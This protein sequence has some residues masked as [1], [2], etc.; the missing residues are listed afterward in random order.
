MTRQ[1]LEQQVLEGNASGSGRSRTIAAA[2]AATMIGGA[3]LPAVTDTAPEVIA[4]ESSSTGNTIEYKF[5]DAIVELDR[6]GLVPK[7]VTIYVN[8]KPVTVTK[9]GQTKVE[10]AKHK[11]FLKDNGSY[12]DKIKTDSAFE[13]YRKNPTYDNG[14]NSEY[15]LAFEKF[16]DLM[17]SRMLTVDGKMTSR[18]ASGGTIWEY[19][20]A[21]TGNDPDINRQNES[22]TDLAKIQRTLPGYPESKIDGKA[23]ITTMNYLIR[24]YEINILNPLEAALYGAAMMKAVSEAYT[25]NAEAQQERNDLIAKYTTDL[26]AV[27]DELSNIKASQGELGKDK[28][29]IHTKVSEIETKVKSLYQIFMPPEGE[30][31]ENL[32]TTI[33]NMNNELI[34]IKNTLGE[35]SLLNSDT[36]IEKLDKLLAK[37]LV[38]KG[39]G[40]GSSA[41]G[42]YNVN[43]PVDFR[44]LMNGFEEQGMG[45]ST[46]HGKRTVTLST[47]HGPVKIVEDTE[48]YTIK[49]KIGPVIFDVYQKHTRE[50]QG[51][52][53]GNGVMKAET[54]ERGF[55]AGYGGAEEGGHGFNAGGGINRSVYKSKVKN[56]QG[57]TDNTQ[58][59][60]ELYKLH[61]FV[62][63]LYRA[64]ENVLST[65][66]VIVNGG[67]DYN[68]PGVPS[69][70][71][72]GD[73]QE[74]AVTA[75]VGA[76]LDFGKYL[77]IGANSNFEYS[78]DSHP[79]QDS[80]EEV[81]RITGDI[82]LDTGVGSEI[83]VNSIILRYTPGA[84]YSEHKFDHPDISDANVPLVESQDGTGKL[85]G[86]I[87][88]K[89]T[90]N[91]RIG[92]SGYWGKEKLVTPNGE[93]AS[94]FH[95]ERT[96]TDSGVFLEF[97]VDF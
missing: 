64:V 83:G 51:T 93:T 2:V 71:V 12:F 84:F 14:K 3:T 45:V 43:S 95:R 70:S 19:G 44:Y 68:G 94:P 21:N 8:G 27:M 40:G 20:A 18:S 52:G 82:Y 5:G 13:I 92:I 4:Q 38:C 17:Y 78:H 29:T 15:I 85:E 74:S 41:E 54:T 10:L 1:A 36:V 57:L 90:E 46:E 7:P 60:H 59:D 35:T 23:G 79:R 6:D 33:N 69:G 49:G 65:A 55:N 11:K 58:R 72:K 34:V 97:G 42:G 50:N 28:R 26:Q 32:Y 88:L 53:Q 31:P 9:V 22:R 91:T 86:A 76:A 87:Q 16:V 48:G 96:G 77:R 89:P 25:A 39:G 67:V 63:G 47:D 37:K 73:A 80:I 62:N 24:D 30:K 56:Q 66:D 75:R 81:H 61:L